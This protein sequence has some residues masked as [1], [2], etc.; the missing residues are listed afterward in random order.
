[1]RSQEADKVVREMEQEDAYKRHDRLDSG[2]SEE[3]KYS[4]VKRPGFN[5]SLPRNSGMQ[6]RGRGGRLR[7]SNYQSGQDHFDGHNDGRFHRNTGS[8]TKRPQLGNDRSF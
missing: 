6:S 7:S 8:T 5:S 4:S 2:V 3:D 1:M